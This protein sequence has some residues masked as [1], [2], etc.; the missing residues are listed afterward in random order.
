MTLRDYLKKIG[1]RDEVEWH[2]AGAWGRFYGNTQDMLDDIP[3]HILSAEV[4]PTHTD[5]G[6]VVYWSAASNGRL[7]QQ[8]S[9]DA[10]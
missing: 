8:P 3:D 9:D 4:S 1:R 10:D 7:V 2:G 5:D 6:R